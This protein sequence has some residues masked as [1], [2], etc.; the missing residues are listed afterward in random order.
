M[1]PLDLKTRLGNKVLAL[2]WAFSLFDNRQAANVMTI[3]TAEVQAEVSKLRAEVAALERTCETDAEP[4]RCCPHCYDKLENRLESAEADARTLRDANK[5][6]AE[7]GGKLREE[8]EDTRKARDAVTVEHNKATRELERLDA[9][10]KSTAARFS[11]FHTTW[12]R[13]QRTIV[14]RTSLLDEMTETNRRTFAALDASLK[15]VAMQLTQS[16]PDDT[17]EKLVA[18]RDQLREAGARDV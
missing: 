10:S 18:L 14:P 16:H 17:R 8:L 5:G 15:W 13:S 1:K 3:D 4:C 12:V 6:L 9:M 11:E 7:H 2:R